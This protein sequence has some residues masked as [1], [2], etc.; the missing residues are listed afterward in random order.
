MSFLLLLAAEAAPLSA[1]PEILVT[2]SRT[3]VSAEDSPVSSSVIDARRIEALGEIQAVDL[4]RL[5]PGLSV[6]VTGARG[7]QAQIRIRGAE[8]NHALLFI[9]GIAFFF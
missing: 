6:A 5:T 4:L 9:D 3:P 7:T 2:A 1:P 8:A